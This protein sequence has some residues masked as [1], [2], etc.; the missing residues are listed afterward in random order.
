MKKVSKTDTQWRT[1]LTPEEFS[2]TRQKGTE[3]AFSGRYWNTTAHGIYTCVACGNAL[4]ASDAKFDA[5]CGWPS[6][7]APLAPDRVREESDTRYGM[8]RTAVSCC[9]C[10]AH[11]G[12]VFSDGPPPTGRRYCVNSLALKFVPTKQ[13]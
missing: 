5:G 9:Q 10:D 8:L 3:P 6:Y 12:H 13:D 4:F 1:I 2:V 7:Y 11:L